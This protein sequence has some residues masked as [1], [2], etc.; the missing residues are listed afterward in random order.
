MCTILHEIG[1][2]NVI[3][4]VSDWLSSKFHAIKNFATACVEFNLPFTLRDPQISAFLDRLDDCYYAPSTLDCQ[5]GALKCVT[6]ALSFEMAKKHEI[7]FKAMRADC[8]EVS[9]SRLPVS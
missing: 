4:F 9:D 3:A 1:F 5:W 6:G 7:H 8:R 2:K